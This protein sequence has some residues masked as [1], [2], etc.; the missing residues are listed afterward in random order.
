LPTAITFSRRGTYSER[1]SPHFSVRPDGADHQ[2]RKV[3][4]R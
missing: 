1:A 4:S 3:P 2:W